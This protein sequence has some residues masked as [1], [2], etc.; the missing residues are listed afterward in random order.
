MKTAEHLFETQ[1]IAQIREVSASTLTPSPHTPPPHPHLP[2]NQRPRRAST[3][4]HP[5]RVMNTYQ[6]PWSFATA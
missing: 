6:V 5:L 3:N 4:A 2:L 1:N